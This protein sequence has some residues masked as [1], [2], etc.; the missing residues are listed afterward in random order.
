MVI[1]EIKDD[2]VKSDI[3]EKI[4]RELPE[5]FGN[6]KP[7]L[8]YIEALAFFHLRSLQKHGM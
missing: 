1:K 5:W 4:L 6:E 7:L 8:E 3:T 2:L